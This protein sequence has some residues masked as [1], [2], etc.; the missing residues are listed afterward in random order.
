M[1]RSFGIL[2]FVLAAVL[3]FGPA[4][5]PSLAQSGAN[6]KPPITI[7]GFVHQFLP[8]GAVHMNVCKKRDCVPGSKVSYTLAAPEKNPNFEG[9]TRFQKQLAERFKQL[10]PEGVSY[11][12]G[13][14]ERESNALY[15][16][17]V[18]YREARATDGALMITKSTFVFLDKVTLN[19]ISSSTSKKQADANYAMFLV[20]LLAWSKALE[21]A[22]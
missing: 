17:F 11:R 15:N 14:P 6:T 21:G 16:A 12:F 19:I 5:H 2:T 3:L 13:A 1:V 7:G 22:E 9:F 8:E 20:G 4:I 10:S 18:T